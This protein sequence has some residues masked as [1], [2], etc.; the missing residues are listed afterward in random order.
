MKYFKILSILFLSSLFMVSC[1]KENIDEVEEEVV[2]EID[3]EITISIRG[4]TNTYDA[5]AAYCDDGSDS[6]QFWQ[7][8][9]NTLLLGEEA[10]LED[11]Q[12]NDFLIFYSKLGNEE[13][14]YAG[15]TFQDI[16]NGDTITST[17]L[18]PGELTVT[19]ANDQHIEGTM[20]GVFVLNNGEIVD[21][22]TE[23]NAEVIQESAQCN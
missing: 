16:M 6:V 21:Y 8:S 14:S 7:V 17:I 13:L 12:V 11:F 9:N 18:G 19:E 4:E 20:E 10:M 23:F 22:F 2:E 15:A 1:E 3:S 5:F